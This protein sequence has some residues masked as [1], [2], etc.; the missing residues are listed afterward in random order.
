[1]R[2]T[3]TLAT[4]FEALY[5]N[6]VLHVRLGQ[7]LAFLDRLVDQRESGEYLCMYVCVGLTF[8]VMHMNAIFIVES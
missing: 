5:P 7:N 6:S 3:V 8:Y 2:S 1:M 4:Y